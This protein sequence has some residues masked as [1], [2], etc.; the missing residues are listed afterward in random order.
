MD[1]RVESIFKRDEYVDVYDC[2][3]LKEWIRKNMDDGG[4]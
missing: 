3:F 2:C 1:N 4:N